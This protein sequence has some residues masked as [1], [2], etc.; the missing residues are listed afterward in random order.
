V[1]TERTELAKKTVRKYMYLS[2]GAGLVPVPLIDLAAITAIQLKMVSA[3]AKQYELPFSKQAGKA[4][5]GSLIGGAVPNAAGGPIGSAVK[6]VPIVGQTIGAVTI[7][8]FAGA[9]T[10]AVG[11]VFINHFESGGTMLDFNPDKVREYYAEQYEKGKTGAVRTT[12][13]K[14]E[15]KEEKKVS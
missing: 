12:T 9:S 11:T 15:K 1:T 10:Y 14:E 13:T 8:A 5:V 4:V 3:L 7:P 2:M 6:A